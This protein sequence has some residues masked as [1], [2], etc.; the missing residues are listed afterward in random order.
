MNAI[1][2]VPFLVVATAMSARAADVD[3][4]SL[5]NASM[6]E[7]MTVI[8]P[9]EPGKAPF[10]NV[11]SKAFIH[12]PAFDFEKIPGALKYRFVVTELANGKRH[13]FFADVPWAPVTPVW[14]AVGPGYVLVVAEG[15]GVNDYPLGVS[16]ARYCYRAAP[17]RGPYPTGSGSY[18]AAALRCFEAIYRLP[19]VQQWLKQKSP[20]KG[21]DLYCY[22]SKILSS[23][24][25]AMTSYSA[26]VHGKESDRAIAISRNMADWLIGQSQ[27]GGGAAG[28]S[29]AD[30]LGG[31]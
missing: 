29:P 4:E 27:P 23:M 3:W 2:G 16:G 19:Y 12:P 6:K 22:P 9:G 8:R 13:E 30:L 18:T 14:A 1:L 25:I 10:W 17:F 7:S 5:N 20:P 21:Y 24:I 15:I 26:M 28:I 11:K 31:S